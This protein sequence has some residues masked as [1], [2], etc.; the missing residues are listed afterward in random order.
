ML[1]LRERRNKRNK[2]INILYIINIILVLYYYSWALGRWGPWAVAPPT[3]PQGRAWAL[4][5]D[6]QNM[7]D[8]VK[9]II[10]RLEDS[11]GL[12]RPLGLKGDDKKL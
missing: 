11:V 12:I 6:H 7:E 1:V 8:R 2:N 10:G 5:L 3:L 4:F 9:D